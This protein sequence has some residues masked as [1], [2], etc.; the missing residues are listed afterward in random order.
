MAER[1]VERLRVELRRAGEQL[2]WLSK[3]AEVLHGMAFEQA[4]NGDGLKVADTRTE[5]YLDEIGSQVAR[6]TWDL[7]RQVPPDIARVVK[8]LTTQFSGMGAD[9]DLRGTLIAPGEYQEAIRAQR[10]RRRNGDFTPVATET[11]PAYPRGN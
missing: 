7:L 9:T 1:D 5:Y 4:T 10:R 11:Q 3:H 2:V 6:R 8:R